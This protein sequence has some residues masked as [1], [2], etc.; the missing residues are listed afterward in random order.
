[1]SSARL[2]EIPSSASPEADGKLSPEFLIAEM[3][4][5]G[6]PRARWR[7]GGEFERA[8]VR[9]DGRPVSYFD[10]DGIRWILETM[11]ER[12]GWQIVREGENPIALLRNGAEISL[13]AEP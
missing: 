11:A 12:G 3:G 13:V 10:E 2:P 1:M 7:V 9:S 8:V 4:R 6:K 5:Y